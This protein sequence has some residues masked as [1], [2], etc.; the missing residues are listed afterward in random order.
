[1]EDI[2]EVVAVFIVVVV[3]GVIVIVHV[4]EPKNLALKDGKKWVSNC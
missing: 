3:H 2:V 1:M 4:V